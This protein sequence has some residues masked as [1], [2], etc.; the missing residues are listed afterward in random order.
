VLFDRLTGREHLVFVA[1]STAF[2]RGESARRAE[3][4]LATM[5]LSGD[6]RKLIADYSFGMRKKAGGW[7]R[8]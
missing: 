3:E 4:L 6:A 2:G 7:R 8:P 1:A 5:E